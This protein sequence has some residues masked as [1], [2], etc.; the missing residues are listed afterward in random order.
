MT[1]LSNKHKTDLISNSLTRQSIT[2]KCSHQFEKYIS[3]PKIQ[4]S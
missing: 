4:F 2:F 1:D 3:Q